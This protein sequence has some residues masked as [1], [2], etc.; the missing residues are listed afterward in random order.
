MGTRTKKPMPLRPISTVCRRYST[1]SFSVGTFSYSE[2]YE[3]SHTCYADQAQVKYHLARHGS[4]FGAEPRQD[5]IDKATE[6]IAKIKADLI[7]LGYSIERESNF[8]LMV[9]EPK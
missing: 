4:A 5:S 7:G 3:I 1:A 2:G 8:T 6:V 9:K